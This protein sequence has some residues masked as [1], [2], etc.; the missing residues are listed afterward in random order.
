MN[1][2]TKGQVFTPNGIVQQMLSL[3]KRKGRILEPSA[4]NGAFSSGLKNCVAIEK[5][6]NIATP[7][8]TARD[9]FDYSPSEKFGTIIG[10]PP[11]VRHNDIEN[12][13]KKKLDYKLFDKRTNLYLFFIEKCLKH[14]KKNGELIFITPR[15][16]INLTSARHL[17]NLMFQ[18]GTITHFIDLGDKKVFDSVCPNVAIWR[19][20]KDN[21][22][23]QTNK[24][25][26][27]NC[28]NGKIT[29]TKNKNLRL[30][31]DIFDVKVGAVSGADTI[32]TNKQGNAEFVCSKTSE[33]NQTRKMIY[34]IRHTELFKHK[35]ILIKR[36]IKKFNENNWWKW[37]R[38]HHKSDS[39]RIYVNCKTRNK[40]PFFTHKTKNYDGSVL[41]LFP[42]KQININKAIQELNKTNWQEQGFICGGRFIFSQRSLSNAILDM[43]F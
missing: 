22:S 12:D 43:D 16:F 1:I 6:K 41:A 26:F 39:P 8:A 7:S 9:F 25:Q 4:G 28:I 38:D 37:G 18:Q 20:E 13:T 29:F 17:N 31:S 15:E 34:N 36:K 40:N 11:Y 23:R 3:R 27:F 30:L 5:D 14:L 10:N 33:T 35:N 2:E 19:F 32:F 24:N 42:K 21:F